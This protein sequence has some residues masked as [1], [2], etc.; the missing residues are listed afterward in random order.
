VNGIRRLTPREL[1]RLQGF[2]DSF[3]IVVP[4]TQIRKQ[5]GN[6]VP[7]IEAVAKEILNSIQH[8][9]AAPQIAI[10]QNLWTEATEIKNEF[11]SVGNRDFQDFKINR[12]YHNLHNKYWQINNT[13]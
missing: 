7:V 10:Q 11:P 9:K 13:L 1:L 8:K 3:K 4:Y 2:P 5:A 6:S 12:S